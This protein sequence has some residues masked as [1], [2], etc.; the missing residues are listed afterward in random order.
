MVGFMSPEEN[1]TEDPT[2][3][4]LNTGVLG[5]MEVVQI[6]FN[7]NQVDY[8]DLCKHFFTLHDPT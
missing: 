3:D 6:T 1:I 2:Y 7:P 5:H 4:E 8:S